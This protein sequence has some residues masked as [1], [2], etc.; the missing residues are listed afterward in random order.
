MF[1]RLECVFLFS[2]VLITT[3]AAQSTR[4]SLRK[5]YV[6]SFS[7]Y[8]FLWPVL[9]QRQLSFDVKSLTENKTV[10]FRPNNSYSLGFGTYLFDL[11]L[12]L[13]FAIPLDEKSEYRYGQSTARD[14][15][16]NALSKKWGADIYYQKYSGFY[17]T[18]DDIDPDD[19]EPYPQR[20]DITTRN[21]GV[22]GMY[23][24]HEHTYSLRSAFTFAERQIKRGGSFLLAGSLN[25]FKLSADSAVL[26]TLSLRQFGKGASLIELKLTTLSLAPG[27]GYNF[28]YNNFFLSGALLVGPAHNWI[29]YTVAEGVKND[30]RFNTYAVFRLG[31]GY[32]GDRLFGGFNFSVQTRA[33]RIEDQQFSNQSTTFRMLVGY[34]FR[35]TGVLKK[36]VWDFPRR[37]FTRTT[38]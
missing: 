1:R 15:Q 22:A 28:V 18:G 34:R 3:T 6:E 38:G 24:F 33:A 35:E 23:V 16:V 13:T 27:Y 26:D 2:L 32:N 37:L 5:E 25:S 21:F 12:E 9:K 19:D 30:I 10:R 11:A 17:E 20:S 29:T 8:F 4:D 36:S 7:E 14:W 31:I